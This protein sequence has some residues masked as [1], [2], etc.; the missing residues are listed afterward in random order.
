ME[1]KMSHF[2]LPLEPSSK[3]PELLHRNILESDPVSFQLHVLALYQPRT[4]AGKSTE[5]NIRG[6]ITR[7]ATKKRTGIY[8]LSYTTAL[9]LKTSSFEFDKEKNFLSDLKKISNDLQ[10][11][12][13]MLR[14]FLAIKN[15]RI[16]EN[17]IGQF[18]D[19]EVSVSELSKTELK[20]ETKEL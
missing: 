9:G 14:K 4:S 20:N 5:I 12:E 11:S 1:P 16:Y 19:P 3:D 17:L 10:C 8:S 6:K 18:T 2:H 13:S 7:T 15:I